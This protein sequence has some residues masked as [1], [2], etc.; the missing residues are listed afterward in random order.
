M[1]DGFHKNWETPKTIEA[2]GK[3]KIWCERCQTYQ[4]F[5]E[6]NRYYSISNHL[7]IVFIRGINYKNRSKIIFN[8]KMN[9]KNYIEPDINSPKNFYLVGSVNRKIQNDVEEYIPYYRNPSN[10]TWNYKG[11]R[12]IQ[13]NDNEQIIILF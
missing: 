10:E 7:I 11:F 6:F 1:K 3:N 2:N 13:R 8:E 9:L 12:D 5:K 4:T